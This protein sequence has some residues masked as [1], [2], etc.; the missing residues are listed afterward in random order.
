MG[1]MGCCI[2][3][4]LSKCEPSL[5]TLLSIMAEDTKVL[6]KCLDGLLTESI[7]LRVVGSREA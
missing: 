1:R 7:S 4:K 3:G 2:V 5:P 6:F